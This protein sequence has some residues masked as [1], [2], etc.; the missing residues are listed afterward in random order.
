MIA[1]HTETYRRHTARRLEHLAS[2]DLPLKGRR[3]LDV[4]AGVGDH[5]SFYLDRGC[6]VVSIEPRRDNVEFAQAR[7][8]EAPDLF[9]SARW[10]VL[11]ADVAQAPELGLGLFDVVHMYGLLYHLEVPL[12]ALA[13]LCTLSRDLVLVE[14]A[15]APDSRV[16]G[17]RFAEDS[18]D[19]TNAV[20]GLCTVVPR[21][22]IVETLRSNLGH[23][24]YCRTQP[25]HPQFPLDWSVAN[26]DGPL[27]RTEVHHHRFVAIGSRAALT[28]PTLT[29]EQPERYDVE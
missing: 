7:L 9:P 23:G 14:T 8:R 5:A 1:F 21:A 28:L 4:G 19:S 13:A 29:I 3:V 6:M 25:A 18:D 27:T 16:G 24:Y 12:K 20:G 22:E 17:V 26:S 15:C 10:S 2:L 11:C